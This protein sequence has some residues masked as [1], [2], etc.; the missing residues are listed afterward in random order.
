MSMSLPSLTIPGRFQ[1]RPVRASDFNATKCYRYDIVS[2]QLMIP[3]RTIY[4]KRL[5]MHPVRSLPKML[6]IKQSAAHRLCNMIGHSRHAGSSR[7]NDNEGGSYWQGGWFVDFI[8]NML[9]KLLR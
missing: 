9:P 1:T 8:G 6:G 5:T 2:T 3:T 7:R 4:R